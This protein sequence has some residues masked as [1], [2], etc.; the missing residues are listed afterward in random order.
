MNPGRA[1]VAAVL[2]W[3]LSTAGW[4][5]PPP[6]TSGA[7]ATIRGRLVDTGGRGVAGVRVWVE[8]PAGPTAGP[9]RR[10]RTDETGAFS[11]TAPVRPAPEELTHRGLP[12]ASGL[13]LRASDLGFGGLGS[14]PSL[15]FLPVNRVVPIEA[16]ERVDLGD[17][18]VR[19]AGLL[20]IDGSRRRSGASPSRASAT[21]PERSGE[22]LFEGGPGRVF[23]TTLEGS[24]IPSAPVELGDHFG[25]AVPTGIA[26]AVQLLMETPGF[27]EVLTR[28]DNGGE[29]YRLDRPGSVVRI[30][31]DREAL[32]TAAARL[33]RGAGDRSGR[34]LA[35][36]VAEL[37]ARTTALLERGA[38][39]GTG[40]ARRSED[41]YLDALAAVLDL[42]EREVLRSA[43]EAIPQVRQ[44][45]LAVRLVDDTGSP[46]VG[47]EVSYAMDRLAFDLGFS[48]AGILSLSLDPLLREMA[49]AGFNQVLHRP[50]AS[51]T[52]PEPG[53]FHLLRRPGDGALFRRAGFTHAAEGLVVLE[54]GADSR[55]LAGLPFVELLARVDRHVRRVVRAFPEVDRWIVSH[56]AAY[57]S[58]SLGLTRHQAVAVIDAAFR[59]LAEANPDAEGGVYLGYP[60]GALAGHDLTADDDRY[61]LDPYAFTAHLLEAGVPLDFLAL[62]I[63]A[64]SCLERL[65]ESAGR[66]ALDLASVADLLDRYARLGI[67]IRLTEVNFPSRP[68]D[69]VLGRW[70]REPDEPLQAEWATGLY[71]VAFSRDAVREVTWYLVNDDLYYRAGIGLF[72]DRD[73]PKPALRALGE[74]IG[75][76]RTDGTAL[77]D[78][79]GVARWRGYYGDYEVET[80]GLE[81]RAA[82]RAEGATVEVV[83]KRP[84]IGRTAAVGAV[85][86]LALALAG[87]VAWKGEWDR[88]AGVLFLALGAYVLA[89]R[90]Q[91]G[92]VGLALA[93][94]GLG[95]VLR[96]KHLASMGA[97]W[98]AAYGLLDLAYPERYPD[99]LLEYVVYAVLRTFHSIDAVAAVVAL[100]LLPA[101]V[102]RHRLI[103]GRV[104]LVAMALA[105][106]GAAACYSRD[107]NL[108]A[109]DLPPW[110]PWLLLT[111]LANPIQLPAAAA[112]L[113][114]ARRGWLSK[115]SRSAG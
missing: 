92:M 74:L 28:L 93:S 25:L 104:L 26:V 35:G 55:D 115:R 69:C 101:L 51:Q 38:A 41:R 12:L 70:H 44:G 14:L 31:R 98:G 43:R 3:L 29:G 62:P 87:L 67:P 15:T 42:T 16:G 76:W 106:A 10:T 6:G 85:A 61:T 59:A 105:T 100:L 82:L 77:T 97:L 5:E 4:A 88:F 9:L 49:G 52:E 81:G 7:A 21:R 8:A 46:L 64:G 2:V 58:T 18:T 47:R 75:R 40:P 78:D 66:V 22:P 20:L 11:L 71:T 107:V 79:D 53:R 73:R 89:G 37:L 99:P 91:V 108:L 114:L 86:A 54:P 34:A 83:V 57:R 1:V 13:G 110:P 112:L 36:D 56:E 23:L 84:G 68:D 80:G 103:S 109:F 95:L 50:Y 32:R 24:V 30:D 39:S 27:G 65:H 17:I 48:P 72:D 90:G 102:L 45:E 19:P 60:E 96:E 63:T 111:T 33:L 94:G 113:F